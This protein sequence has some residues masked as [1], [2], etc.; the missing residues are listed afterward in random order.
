MRSV[1]WTIAVVG[2]LGAGSGCGGPV[3]EARF[4]QQ[5]DRLHRE[6]LASAVTTDPDLGEYVQEIGKRVIDA[7][8]VVVPRQAG[9]ELFSQVRFHL[10]GSPI[11]N[12]FTTGGVHV[13]VYTSLFQLCDNE[14]ELAAAI[15]H[16]YAHVLNLDVEKTGMRADARRPLPLIAYDF[17][18]LRFTVEQE[19]AADVLAFNLYARAGWDPGRFAAL[20]DRLR[21]RYGGGPSSPDRT[22]LSMRVESARGMIGSTSRNWRQIPVADPRTFTKL[23]QRVGSL[24]VQ[25]GTPEAQLFLR[26]FP[27]CLLGGDTAEQRDAQERLKPPPPPPVQ[28]EPS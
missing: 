23:R 21:D 14:D 17:V 5:A 24:R 22:S 20:F 15:A 19:Q 16:E 11:V 7:A 12:A 8:K 18:T 13:Y 4:V 28:V 6:A 1:T 26:A 25:G 10:V 2:L 9:A 3:P 27:N